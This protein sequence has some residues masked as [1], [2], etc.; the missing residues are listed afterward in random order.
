[1][2]FKRC[3]IL[4]SGLVLALPSALVFASTTLLPLDEPAMSLVAPPDAVPPISTWNYDFATQTTTV[5][6]SAP[7]L[8]GNT[9]SAMSSTAI[10]SVY[11]SVNGSAGSTPLPFV[12]GS[13][14]M[15]PATSAVAYGAT[16][17]GYN[18]DNVQFGGDPLG[19]LVC[20]GLDANGVHRLTRGLFVD[21]FEEPGTDGLI[22]NSTVSVSVFHL[23]AGA[24]NNYYGYTIDVTI[25]SLPG[26]TNC[27]VLDCNFALIEGFDSSVFDPASGGWCLAS[28]GAQSCPGAWTTGGININYSN[29]GSTTSLAAPVGAAQPLQAHFVVFRYFKSGV[30][31]LPA[32]GAPVAMAALFSPQDL[33]ENKLDDN[34]ATG[35]NTLANVAPSV[36]NDSALTVLTNA[37]AALQENTDSGSLTFT[38]GDTDSIESAGN[39]LGASVTLNLPTG[40]Q[41]PVDANCGSATPITTLP[42]SRTC[43]IDIPLDSG[44]FWDND[45]GAEYQGQFNNVAT[46]ATNG[47]YAAGVSASI[48]IVATDAQGKSGTATT[49]PVHIFSSKND[50]PVATFDAN[51]LP[52]VPNPNDNNSLYSTYACSIGANNCGATFHIA[53]L[54]SVVTAQPGP[55]AAF[56]ELAAQTTTADDLQCAT[57]GSAPQLTFANN[58]VITP[59]S[60]S[61]TLYDIAFQFI[62]SPAQG[63]AVCT[64]TMSDA[65]SGGFPNSESTATATP[66]P[67]FRIVVNP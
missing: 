43:T 10:K 42:V 27:N 41:V 1:M 19:A 52:L 56:D 13:S 24:P 35:N 60:G 62:A 2:Q 11:Y 50:A 53:T 21:G 64:I 17:F 9:A 67:V 46:D 45:V 51:Q 65:Q 44:T 8:C 34:V 20:Y 32:S 49:L 22:A 55:I 6:P 14:A 30:G 26:G 18:G 28:A 47:T 31:M 40:I 23:P 54:T 63:S 5:L 37:V 61:P 33:Q 39:L 12:F 58:P 15:A 7:L 48:K 59:H 36:T 38:I 57:D 29:F 16:G 3:S 25:P 4:M 66:S